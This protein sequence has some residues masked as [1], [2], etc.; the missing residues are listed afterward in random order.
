MQKK[1]RFKHLVL[2][3]SKQRVVY[4]KMLEALP[5]LRRRRGCLFFFQI[6]IQIP[7]IIQMAN[8]LFTWQ[9]GNDAHLGLWSCI[10]RCSFTIFILEL[11]LSE[12]LRGANDGWK[13]WMGKMTF[14]LCCDRVCLANLGPKD[15]WELQ[16]V[17]I[18]LQ[19]WTCFA[20]FFP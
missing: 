10:F 20:L 7:I 3:A 15:R 4:K 18:W 13:W 9:W 14:C 6:C 17:E 8:K 2:E 1:K 16:R 12:C 19:G 5:K 11:L